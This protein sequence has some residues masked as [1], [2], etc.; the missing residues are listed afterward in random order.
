MS[1]RGYLEP[2]TPMDRLVGFLLT[3]AS[4]RP[5][6]LE[7]DPAEADEYDLRDD[8]VL[9][10][11]TVE[12]ARFA[13]LLAEALRLMSQ[14]IHAEDDRYT[15]PISSARAHVLV[16]EH[17]GLRAAARAI[18]C[19]HTALRRAMLEAQTLTS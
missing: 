8:G 7:Y 13:V 10:V 4:R 16:K 17:G 18:G 19:S 12:E 1:N 15:T 3:A 9:V 11:E 14:D 2:E 5:E 6:L